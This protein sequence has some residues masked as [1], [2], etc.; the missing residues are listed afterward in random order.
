MLSGVYNL[1]P[2]FIVLS[3]YQ[4]F[5]SGVA[6]YYHITLYIFVHKKLIKRVIDL[7]HGSDI[8]IVQES[9]QDCCDRRL[10]LN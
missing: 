10:R 7:N 4:A 3:L 6:P 9:N 8:P 5:A 2:S 1:E